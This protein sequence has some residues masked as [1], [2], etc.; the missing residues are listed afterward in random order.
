NIANFCSSLTFIPG[1]TNINR[2]LYNALENDYVTNLVSF[3]GQVSMVESKFA[4]D[5]HF[6]LGAW[7]QWDAADPHVTATATAVLA[8]PEFPPSILP[9]PRAGAATRIA[10]GSDFSLALK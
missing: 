2:N 7:R 10:A 3:Y 9:L 6:N 1:T 4:T 8:A 5:N